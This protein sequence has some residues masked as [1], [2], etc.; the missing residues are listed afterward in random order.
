VG[1]HA[2][3]APQGHCRDRDAPLRNVALKEGLEE[4]ASPATPRSGSASARSG[5]GRGLLSGRP[6]QSLDHE[7]PAFNARNTWCPCDHEGAPEARQKIGPG[8]SPGSTGLGAQAPAGRQILGGGLIP[9]ILPP[10]LGLVRVLRITHSL[11][12]GLPSA[13]APRLS[14]QPTRHSWTDE[15]RYSRRDLRSSA[16]R[17]A[18]PAGMIDWVEPSMLAMSLRWMIASGRQHPRLPPSTT[19]PR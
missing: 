4:L 17:V 11:R 15:A 16:G 14:G 5:P 9:E 18:K 6:C 10:R 3:E 12:C 1:D 2:P 8:V 19:D 7:I 13:A